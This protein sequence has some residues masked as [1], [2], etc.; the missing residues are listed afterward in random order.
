MAFASTVLTTTQY[1]DPRALIV[2]GTVSG[3]HEFSGVELTVGE[4]TIPAVLSEPAPNWPFTRTWTSTYLLPDGP[5]PDG[6]TVQATATVTVTAMAAVTAAASAGQGKS[7]P[8]AAKVLDHRIFLPLVMTP[9]RGAGR[10]ST[11]QTLTLDV[12]PPA[13]VD[14]TL[15]ANGSPLAPN[16]I[17]RTVAP[18]LTLE[19]T[20]SQDGSGLQ[21]Y[22]TRWTA[23]SATAVAATTTVT[24]RHFDPAGPLTDRYVGGE[25]QSLTVELGSRDSYGNERWQ[26]IGPIY[27]DSPETPDTIAPDC[28]RVAGER[29]HAHGHR[30]PPLPVRADRSSPAALRDLGS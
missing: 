4:S 2:E 21:G 19:W 28:A 1:H 5:L 27:L 11:E 23:T 13:A 25:A 29:L 18:E 22:T 20:A 7:S 9:D 16:A 24:T 17:V 15:A 3:T 12:V 6:E 30:P 10:Y 26:Q 8:D 14:L